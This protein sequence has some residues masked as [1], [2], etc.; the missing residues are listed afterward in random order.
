MGGD[1]SMAGLPVVSVNM[2]LQT[3]LST[4]PAAVGFLG[5]VEGDTK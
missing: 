3:P 1:D 5:M 4:L 2:C